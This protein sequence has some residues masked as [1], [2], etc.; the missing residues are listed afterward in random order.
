MN[1]LIG[2]P[3]PKCG[4]RIDQARNSDNKLECSFFGQPANWCPSQKCGAD[5]VW[6]RDKAEWD[7]RTTSRTRV[8]IDLEVNDKPDA[9]SY[10]AEGDAHFE[11]WRYLTWVLDK[12]I[13]GKKTPKGFKGPKILIQ[14]IHSVNTYPDPAGSACYIEKQ[15]DCTI[16]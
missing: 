11:G 8:Y 12:Y 7:V 4:N 14:Q 6:N 1:T 16:C 15:H 13:N 10:N 9:D 2:G 3:C 5:V